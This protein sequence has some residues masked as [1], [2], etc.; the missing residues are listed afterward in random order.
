LE[1]S[2]TAMQV[3]CG[4][5]DADTC[6]GALER[7][8]TFSNPQQ[9]IIGPCSH[10]CRF[11]VDPFLPA[12]GHTPPNPTP[13][14]Q[15]RVRAD[16]FDRY[17]KNDPPAN[18]EPGIQYY[19][20]GEGQWHSTKVWPPAQF[21]QASRRYY[22]GAAH[23]LD[24]EAPETASASDSYTVDFTATTGQ[25]TRWHTQ[26]GG[27]DVIYPDRREADKQL[28]VYTSAP[29]ETDV[30]ITGSPVI[31]L[32]IASTESDG[33]V[34]AY[35]EDVAPEGR[36]TYLDEGIFR[37][38]DRKIPDPKTMPFK[39]FGPAHSLLRAD[40]EPFL[41]GQ[42]AV[43]SFGLFPTSLLL[44]KGHSIRVALAGADAPLFR[45]YPP[46]GK[47]TWTLYHER[48]RAS[49]IDLPLRAR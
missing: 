16:F 6:E 34:H 27:L 5:L 1:S 40:A 49:Y 28:L 31:S 36:V 32:Q 46:Q 14:E 23:R 19:T 33:A 8:A 15:W 12:Q 13:E 18:V 43:L 41:P 22:F 35:L 38:V 30:E 45:R 25:R 9:L 26:N 20:M 4:W 2:G 44:R 48:T 11:N 39:V 17:L 37:I 47:P 7:Y 10:G 29:L 24:L 3:W 42:P 21:A